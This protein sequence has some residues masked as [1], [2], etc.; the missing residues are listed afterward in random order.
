MSANPARMVF[1]DYPLGH[2]AGPPDDPATQLEIARSA[3]AA[4]TDIT[5]PGGVVILPHEWPTEWKPAARELKDDRAPRFDT[6]QYQHEADRDA[7][8]EAH[9]A[10]AAC[11]VCAPEAVP[12]H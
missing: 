3:M 7:A 2:T 9:G 6:P 5:E 11:E 8:I 4:F 12:T 10:V 1:L